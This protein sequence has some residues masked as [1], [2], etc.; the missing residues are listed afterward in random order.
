MFSSKKK[1]GLHGESIMDLKDATVARV[2]VKAGAYGLP[3]EVRIETTDGRIFTID[4]A[5]ED[6][7]ECGTYP[8]LNFTL[9][10]RRNERTE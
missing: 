3:Q 9:R 6:G 10:Q 8:C 5:G 1:K 2:V 4:G 7:G